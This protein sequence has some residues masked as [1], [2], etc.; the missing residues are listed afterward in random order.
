MFTFYYYRNASAGYWEDARTSTSIPA[1]IFE[2]FRYAAGDYGHGSFINLAIALFRVLIDTFFFSEMLVLHITCF[3]KKVDALLLLFCRSHLIRGPK[4]PN[5]E[6][7]SRS[8][9]WTIVSSIWFSLNIS[10][11]PRYSSTNLTIYFCSKPSD[12][13][14]RVGILYINQKYTDDGNMHSVL[15]FDNLESRSPPPRGFQM[16][17]YKSP[18]C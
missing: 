13:S 17:L 7:N 4:Q 2:R 12:D 18:K 15:Q 16:L 11:G 1:V 3:L 9:T 5:H 10:G 6:L 8:Y 14:S